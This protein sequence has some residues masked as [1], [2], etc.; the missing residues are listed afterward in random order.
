MTIAEFLLRLATDE[1]LLRQFK[2]D[3]EGMLL[4]EALSD[5]D[6]RLLLSGNTDELRVKVEAEFHVHGQKVAYHTVY[7][8][9]GTVY[10]PPPPPPPPESEY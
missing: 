9:P 3:R 1:E 10:V 8:V 7:T 2:D 6:R 4:N 5:E